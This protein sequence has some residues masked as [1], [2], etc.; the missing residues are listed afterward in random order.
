M[1][2]TSVCPEEGHLPG[3]TPLAFMNH[4]FNLQVIFEEFISHDF[5]EEFCWNTR[6]RLIFSF[7][8]A[9]RL[10]VEGGMRL[11]QS[12]IT[13]CSSIDGEVEEVWSPPFQSVAEPVWF[14]QTLLLL[15]MDPNQVNDDGHGL[16]E[17]I[18][19]MADYAGSAQKLR[20]LY[21]H[22]LDMGKED[23]EG[24]TRLDRIMEAFGERYPMRGSG[25]WQSGPLRE[26]SRMLKVIDADVAR[27]SLDQCLPVTSVVLRGVRL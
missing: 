26:F 3:I 16:A 14:F 11:D 20:L 1:K 7:M 24:V 8:E 12:C 27:K 6:E 25:S 21:E 22:G 9:T 10:L 2:A 15:G 18:V 4:V 13:S 19:A 17:G 23:G 5:D